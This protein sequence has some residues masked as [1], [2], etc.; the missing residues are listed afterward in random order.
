MVRHDV[1]R[2]TPRLGTASLLGVPL[3]SGFPHR[4]PCGWPWDALPVQEALERGGCSGLAFYRRR[5][6][7]C[8]DTLD[9][10]GDGGENVLDLGR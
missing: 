3:R 8:A 9:V 4:A 7:L 1:A 6:V 2:F 5:R 10:D